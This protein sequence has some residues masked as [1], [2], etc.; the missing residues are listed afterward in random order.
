V[1]PAA[2]S[3]SEYEGG[4]S[5]EASDPGATK[6]EIMEAGL[7]EWADYLLDERPAL[8]SAIFL[9]LLFGMPLVIPFGAFNQTA[10][11]IGNRGLRYMLLRTE[12]SNIFFG[13]FIS[14]VLFSLIVNAFAIATITL[15][16]GL[17]LKIYGGWELTSWAL[18]GYIALT[19]QALPYIALCAWLSAMNDGAMLSMIVCSLVIGGV[20]LFAYLGGKLWEPARYLDWLLPWNVHND[21]LHHDLWRILK[22]GGVCILYTIAYLFLGHRHFAKRDL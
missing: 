9:I 21:L 7:Q 2:E 12:R 5:Q 17:K 14:T 10:G 15:Y 8:L 19:L 11:E 13:R 1:K 6:R 16:V 18:Q 3:E 4:D 22:A 20:I